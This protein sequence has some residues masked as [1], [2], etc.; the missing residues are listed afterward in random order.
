MENYGIFMSSHPRT[1]GVE[2]QRFDNTDRGE[3][4]VVPLDRGIENGE[5][6]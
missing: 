5:S 6:P 3:Q 4:P 2:S 1:S